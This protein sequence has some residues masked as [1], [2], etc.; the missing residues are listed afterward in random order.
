MKRTIL[1]ATFVLVGLSV[2]SRAQTSSDGA[3]PGNVVGTGMSLPLGSSASN[4][5]PADTRSDIA[6]NL[7]APDLPAGSRPSDF[8]RA[9]EGALAA[10]R[11]GEAQ[12]ALEMAQTRLLDRSVPLF[13]THNPSD[14]PTVGE[15]SRAMQALAANDRPGCLRS[16]EAAISSA[17]AQGL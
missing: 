7:P 17:S 11:T 4:I 13:Q 3:R 12:D 5:T 9:A 16:I 14:D 6:P 1:L 2:A 15:I 10:G 8:L